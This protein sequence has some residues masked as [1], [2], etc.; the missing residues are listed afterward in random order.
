VPPPSSA[1]NALAL[2]TDQPSG[3]LGAPKYVQTTN[4]QLCNY[5]LSADTGQTYQGYVYASAPGSVMLYWV[6]VENFN[7]QLWSGDITLDT[8]DF[9]N[10]GLV[11]YKETWLHSPSIFLSAGQRRWTYKI[12]ISPN[13]DVSELMLLIWAP[14]CS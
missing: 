3:A 2:Q 6:D 14:A 12:T 13:S 4:W 8:Q 5:I 9:G 1:D 10:L 11:P 7:F